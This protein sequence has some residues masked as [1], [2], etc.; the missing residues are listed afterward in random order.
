MRK[1][2]CLVA[3]TLTAGIAAADVPFTSSDGKFSVT[4]PVK[5]TPSTEPL[6]VGATKLTMHL[7]QAQLAD[8][9]ILVSYLDYKDDGGMTPVQRIE[10]TVSAEVKGQ[11]GTIV[12]KE[13]TCDIANKA[14]CREVI[15]TAHFEGTDL[16]KT[17]RNFLV[18]RRLYQLAVISKATGGTKPTVIRALFDSFKLL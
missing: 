18:G 16:V 8:G 17:F 14:L 6:E 15:Y 12:G 3:I 9:V 5:P 13:A 1:L 2:A 4:L 10:A 11:Q 7:F